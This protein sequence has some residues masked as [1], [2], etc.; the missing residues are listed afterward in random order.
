MVMTSG[1]FFLTGSSGS[2]GFSGILTKSARVTSPSARV[3]MEVFT[4]SRLVAGELR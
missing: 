3:I 4:L 2:A 1:S